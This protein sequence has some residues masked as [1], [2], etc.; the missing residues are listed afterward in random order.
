MARAGDIIWSWCQSLSLSIQLKIGI[1]FFDIR[2]RHF[3]NGLPIHHGQFYENC[4]FADCMN[5]MTS[6][7]KSHPSEVLL[8]RVKEEYKAAKCTRTFCETVWLTFQNYREN[9]WLEEN[10]PSIK[11]VRGKIIILRDF[12]RENNPIGIPYASLD[13]E[14]YWKAFSYNE[15]WRRVKA[16]LDDTRSTT[17]NPI[18]IT[19]NS[20]TMGV[21]APREIAR[22]LKGIRYSFDPV[23]KF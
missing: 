7:V 10:I 21:N 23:F 4:N 16:H 8:V 12:T 22:R 13:I 9:I 11:E 1:R 3:K 6:F 5:T 19:F 17:D 20:C 2:C 18:H 15:K 14:D